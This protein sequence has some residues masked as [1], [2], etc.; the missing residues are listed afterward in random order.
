MSFEV[1]FRNSA[2]VAQ[3]GRPAGRARK[4]ESKQDRDTGCAAA[5]GTAAPIATRRRC[6]CNRGAELR[7]E[8][9]DEERRRVLRLRRSRRAHP[10]HLQNEA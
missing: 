9:S 7:S 4:R 6:P 1:S 5:A 8:I 3:A 10:A 2:R